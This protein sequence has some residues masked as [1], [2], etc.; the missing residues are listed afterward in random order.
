M[1]RCFYMR[2]THLLA[3]TT[4]VLALF[5]AAWHFGAD[6]DT[7][8]VSDMVEGLALPEE[9]AVPTADA[10]LMPEPP[11][12]VSLMAMAAKAFDGRDLKI[13]KV[14]ASN[15]AYT[16]YYI[17]YMSGT[18]KVSG[19]MNVPK[20]KGPFPLLVLNHG[21]ID[22]KIYTNGRGLKREQ[23]Y[24]ARHGYVVLHTDYRGHAQSSP[25]PSYETDI[26]LGYAEDAI[27]AVLAVRAAKLPYV[28][29]EKVGML[30]HSMGGGVTMAS[31][32]A[33]PDLVD[34]AVL[35]APV[36]ADVR[37][38]FARWTVKRPEIAAKIR[39][40]HGSPEEDPAFW[41]GVSPIAHLDRIE[42]PIL[43][44]HGT[45]DE[46]TPH[47]WA[48]RLSAALEKAGKTITFHSYPGEPHEF[49]KAWPL[50]MRRT[51]EFYDRE[52]K[53]TQ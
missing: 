50:V 26:R 42:A 7:P 46:S 6:T 45:A 23:D 2:R 48:E 49:I 35:F 53:D 25:D 13:G 37:D 39:E 24:L 41:D 31:L 51:V 32:V 28:D 40:I 1:L 22:P 15:A 4:A 47:V 33:V 44:H 8:R 14:L 34:A 30:G 19:I 3:T 20:G 52:L 16:R 43:L 27:N 9:P 17:T 29:A 10:E 12:P 36:S 38:N 18:L 21:H 5:G 11:D